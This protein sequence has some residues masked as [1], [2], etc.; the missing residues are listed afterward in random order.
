[1]GN[2]ASFP[3]LFSGRTFCFVCMLHSTHNVP[4]NVGIT[5]CGMWV[6]LKLFLGLLTIWMF[7]KKILDWTSCTFIKP[8]FFQK[9][10]HI[11]LI[12][13]WSVQ[14]DLFTLSTCKS[15]LYQKEKIN[16]YG[17]LTRHVHGKI[18]CLPSFPGHIIYVS[19]D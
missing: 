2:V 17:F 13:T 9:S 11:F 6:D 7:S 19:F 5:S 18:Y 1:M 8:S 4:T 14:D 12:F 16:I 3:L 15:K 10:I